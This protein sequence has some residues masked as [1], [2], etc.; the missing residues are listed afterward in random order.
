MITFL[1][2][3]QTK[4]INLDTLKFYTCIY[5]SDQT[6]LYTDLPE[7][8]SSSQISDINSTIDKHECIKPNR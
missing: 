1:I 5:G 6:L 7:I 4:D 3:L 2:L 8:F